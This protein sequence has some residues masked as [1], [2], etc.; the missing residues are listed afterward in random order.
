[1]SNRD[2]YQHLYELYCRIMAADPEQRDSILDNLSEDDAHL[3]AEL[4]LL[5]AVERD[6]ILPREFAET[7]LAQYR[8]ALEKQ[9][10]GRGA[11]ADLTVHARGAYADG[12]PE[13]IGRYQIIRRI[14]RGGMGSV[15][16]AEQDSPRRTVALKIIRAGVISPQL[17]QRFQYEAE[18]LGRLQHPGIAQIYEAGVFR[19]EDQPDHEPQP[20]FAMELIDGLPITEYCQVHQLGTRE[21]L[22]LLARVS[23]AV[24]HAHQRG[25][26]HRDLKPGNILV[27]SGTGAES[28]ESGSRSGS[29]HGAQPK[30]LDFGVARATDSDI[31][32]TTL[33]TD[34][35]QLIGTVPYMSPEQ[36]SGDPGE[37]DT[38]SDVYAL[39]VL[40]YEVLAGRLPYDIR[41]KMIHESLRIIREDPPTPLSSA[42]RMFRGDVETIVATALTKEK[43][44][45]YQ[46]A[47]AL[48]S[49]IRRY[50]N[51]EPI[52]ARPPSALYQ[53]RKFAQRNRAVVA[54]IVTTVLALVI[55]LAATIWYAAGESEQRALAVD[56]ERIALEQERRAS[57][58]ATEATANMQLATRRAADVTK[59]AAFQ[60]DMLEKLEPADLAHAFI[61]GLRDEIARELALQDASARDEAVAYFDSV[62]NQ[63]NPTT[64]GATIIDQ[65]ILSRATAALDTEFA[66]Q[67]LPRAKLQRTIGRIYR[68]LGHF[69]P[70]A[71]LLTEAIDTITR[72]SGENHPDVYDMRIT[73]SRVLMESGHYDEAYELAT[74]VQDLV[75]AATGPALGPDGELALEALV[76]RSDILMTARRWDEAV[77]VQE[78]ALESLVRAYGSDAPETLGVMVALSTSLYSIG[79]LDEA[80]RLS[81]D[82]IERIRA[83][84]EPG[85]RL[86]S[87]ALSNR[88]QLMVRMKR[89]DEAQ[90]LAKQAWS[91]TRRRVGDN[92][93]DAI[94]GV[95]NI[96][97]ALQAGGKYEEALPYFVQALASSQR[98]NGHDH[99]RTM[100]YA[101]NC[102]YVLDQL[103]RF[104]EA[105]VYLRDV[106]DRKT[107]LYGEDDS[108]TIE[109]GRVIALT[110]VKLGR[111]ADAAPL[112]HKKVEWYRDQYGDDHQ[113][114]LLMMINYAASLITLERYEEA[115]AVAGEAARRAEHVLG[116]SE[117]L[118]HAYRGHH[119]KALMGLGRFQDAAFELERSCTGL[120]DLLGEDNSRVNSTTRTLAELYEKW[121]AAEPEAGHGAQAEI[122]KARIK[123]P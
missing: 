93:P 10:E 112:L 47:S 87:S 39:G 16:E 97:F 114:T 61:T 6:G 89:F 46:S 5:L 88:A 85:T 35:G 67:P 77:P 18:V 121:H 22:E 8:K 62:V 100:T 23:D 91:M 28:S 123:A 72:E 32:T 49:D 53:F 60:E 43:E 90:E 118:L 50:L 45:R 64:L 44:R 17:M 21:R 103:N 104:D 31:Q 9:L 68:R 92:A 101:N 95:S 86:E 1:L 24:Q 99:P 119:G 66:D 2:E 115:E 55:G 98:V 105:E 54:G 84:A 75:S 76:A 82:A 113:Q 20:Y 79:R 108:R 15:Y 80:D 110:L 65:E 57:E 78:T 40:A 94:L 117:W 69:E 3:R 13:R 48:A 38:R 30:V 34:I 7:H 56:N 122:W 58:K 37:I 81:A 26:I 107:R 19:A 73:M 116:E 51:D 83:R 25:V 12:V 11:V 71:A 52:A 41:Q 27:V 96:G 29:A 74:T 70:A 59:I 14:G 106:V 42:N 63:I 120:R 36:A 4:V 111:H 33:R 102:G 109:A